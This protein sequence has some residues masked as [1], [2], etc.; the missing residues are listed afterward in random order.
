[1]AGPQFAGA[2]LNSLDTLAKMRDETDRINYL[3]HQGLNVYA[4]EFARHHDEMRARYSQLLYLQQFGAEQLI[5]QR[6]DLHKLDKTT[7]DNMA[8]EAKKQDELNKALSEEEATRTRILDIIR[9][10][11]YC[12]QDTWV[13]KMAT[14]AEKGVLRSLEESEAGLRQSQKRSRG[15]CA[16]VRKIAGCARCCQRAFNTAVVTK[17]TFGKRGRRRAGPEAIIPLGQLGADNE[18][19]IKLLPLSE[20]E[21]TRQLALLNDQLEDILNPSI[22]Q[23]VQGMGGGVGGGGFGG[24]GGGGGG[25]PGGTGTGPDGTTGVTTPAPAAPIGI[26]GAPVG[27]VMGNHAVRHQREPGQSSGR[28]ER[29]VA[30]I[31]AR[32]G[33]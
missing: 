32:V 30:G 24:G 3:R 16:G 1:M 13:A 31:H 4:N 6:E 14:R 12:R 25:G 22:S 17:P 21:N 19:A 33:G 11:S 18:K 28:A 2:M 9:L 23:A 10:R 27:G 15:R 7:L 5:N 26:T 20:G 29:I 8:A